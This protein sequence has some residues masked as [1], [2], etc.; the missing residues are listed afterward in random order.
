MAQD[1]GEGITKALRVPH[2]IIGQVNRSKPP[3]QPRQGGDE[4]DDVAKVVLILRK[5]FLRGEE[6]QG[7]FARIC[8]H[9]ASSAV[10]AQGLQRDIDRERCLTCFTGRARGCHRAARADLCHESTAVVGESQGRSG[11][12]VPTF[13]AG[14]RVRATMGASA[15]D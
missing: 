4:L 10:V 2:R 13:W 5:P 3:L 14:R 7:A 9:A 8:R 11:A 15:S 12:G 6:A 1:Q